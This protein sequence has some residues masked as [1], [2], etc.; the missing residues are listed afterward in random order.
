[1]L[2]GRK[3]KWAGDA[4][5]DCPYCLDAE[6]SLEHRLTQCPV[7]FSTR[8]AHSDTL[9]KLQDRHKHWIEFP[10]IAL[11]EDILDLRR[12]LVSRKTSPLEFESD[13]VD[14]GPRTGRVFFTDGSCL[15]WCR[16]AAFSIVWDRA[17]NNTIREEAALRYKESGE[18][19]DS[20]VCVAMRHCSAPQ[21]INR[22]ELDLLSYDPRSRRL[23][24]GS[25]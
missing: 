19:P 16:K 20:I 7:F 14:T 6:D 2:N 1:M 12:I 3:A 24:Q 25:A 15:Q 5:G 8:C 4:T 17:A 18:V 22:A 13:I 9:A 21:S 10:Y 23:E 11:S